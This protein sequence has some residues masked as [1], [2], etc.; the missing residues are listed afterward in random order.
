MSSSRLW[1][2]DDDD[3]DD[4]RKTEVIFCPEHHTRLLNLSHFYY[5]S[6]IIKNIVI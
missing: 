6:D 2:A 3:D 4:I 5:K 1:G